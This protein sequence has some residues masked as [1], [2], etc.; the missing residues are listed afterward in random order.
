M[1]C[2]AMPC[3]TIYHTI[4]CHNIKLYVFSVPPWICLLLN[5]ESYC[6]VQLLTSLAEDTDGYN[7]IVLSPAAEGPLD[8]WKFDAIHRELSD[9]CSSVNQVKKEI[10]HNSRTAIRDQSAPTQPQQPPPQR[11]APGL[12]PSLDITAAVCQVSLPAA[13]QPPV[14]VTVKTTRAQSPEDGRE[15]LD[16]IPRDKIG[17][18]RTRVKLRVRIIRNRVADGCMNEQGTV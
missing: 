14:T 6:T 2:H 12:S 4:P 1:P 10:K 17:K 3:H 7:G 16:P 8:G 11:A 5:Y 18:Q 13:L 15:R 9:L